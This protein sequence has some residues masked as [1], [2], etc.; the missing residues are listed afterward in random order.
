VT[1]L[2]F[3]GYLLEANYESVAHLLDPVT[4]MILGTLLVI[5]LWRAFRM[6]RA[7]R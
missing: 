1:L 7:R 6:W 2:A 5:Y 3:A 4:T